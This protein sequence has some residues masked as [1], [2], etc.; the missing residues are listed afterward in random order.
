MGYFNGSVQF[1]GITEQIEEIKTS[2]FTKW[3]DVI[4]GVKRARN[5]YNK[6]LQKGR[7]YFSR[8]YKNVIAKFDKLGDKLDYVIDDQSIRYLKNTVLNSWGFVAKMIMPTLTVQDFSKMINHPDVYLDT[9]QLLTKYGYIS[10]THEVKTDDGYLLSVH[11][12][13]GGKKYPPKIGKPVVFLQHGILASSVVWILTGPTKGLAYILADEGYDV[14]MGNSRG[15]S[16]SR[17]HETLSPTDKMFWDFS[18]HEMGIYDLPAVIDHIL[19]ITGEKKISYI[20]HSQGTT[21]FFVMMSEK[22]EYNDKILKFVAYAPLAFAA[23]IKSPIINFFAK[24]SKPVY[25]GLRLLKMNDFMPT[26]ALLTKIGRYSCE[27]KSLYQVICSNT[28]FMVT[29]YDTAQINKTVVPIILGHLPAG[30][31]IKQFYHFGQGI[32][33]KKFRQFDYIQPDKNRKVYGQP[34]PPEYNVTKTIVP[35]ALFYAENDLLSVVEDVENLSNKLSNL[36]MQHKIPMEMFNHIDFMF[37]IDAPALVY[38]PTIDYL[39]KPL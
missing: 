9:P 31:S 11:R 24:I 8:N 25:H 13:T 7:N 18:W 26:N 37:A 36:E 5:W 33:S 39:K 29:G 27:A 3:I 35:V 17:A 16:Y 22:P 38:Q 2:K 10:E 14:W 30:S 6:M 28:L 4:P 20:G 23:H 34:E 12:I 21:S 19:S 1:F 32:N 15:N